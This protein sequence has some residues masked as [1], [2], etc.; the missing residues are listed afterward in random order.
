MNEVFKA[1][2][3]FFFEKDKL[4]KLLPA[5][6][7]E[8]FRKFLH[9]TLNNFNIF[10]SHVGVYSQ[11]QGVKMGSPLS[12]LFADLFLGMLEGTII[13]NLERQGHIFKWLRYAD[14]CVVIAKKGSFDHIL[15]KV[16]NWDKNIFFSHEKMV[17]N[18]VTF[19]S[20]T[21][22]L[23][24]GSFEFKPSRK[25][26]ADAIITNFQKATISEK[27]LISNIFTM[28]HHSQNSSSNHDILLNDMENSLKQILL[29]N[30]YPL[31][32]IK[33]NFTKFLQNGPKPKPPDVTFTLSIP[34]TS[35]GIDYHLQKLIRQIKNVIPDFHVR[36]AY[37]SVKLANLFSADAKPK[38]V[39]EI[40]T[41]NCVYHFKCLCLSHYVGMTARTIKTRATEHRNPS[42]AKGI[43][44]HIH[45]C[46][47]YLTRL[48]EFENT[49]FRPSDGVRARIKMRDKFFM[50]HFRVLQKSF[51]SYFDRRKSEAISIRI[52]RPDLN[53][54]NDHRSFTLF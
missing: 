34:Y 38:N 41:T 4:G 6:S 33:S 36:L 3:K 17:D 39:D 51:G 9:G 42:K 29:R 21:I 54:Q 22:F 8:N 30:C 13:V 23:M 7:R 53:D 37:K 19:L 16:N 18:E 15:E 10:R 47:N 49:N 20:S 24:N 46:P 26:G 43:Y 11:K 31:K 45:S 1:P 14:D 12:S 48:A 32:T 50:Q 35:K 40:E 27:Y 28:L 52:L 2:E 5:P 44:Y 25:N